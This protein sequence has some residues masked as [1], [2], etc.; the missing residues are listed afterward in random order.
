MDRRRVNLAAAA[1]WFLAAILNYTPTFAADNTEGAGSNGAVNAATVALLVPENFNLP[2]LHKIRL[3]QIIS[4][5]LFVNGCTKFL[6]R[7]F[8]Q[9]RFSADLSPKSRIVTHAA[10]ADRSS[11]QYGFLDSRNL[12]YITEKSDVWFVAHKLFGRR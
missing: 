8:L 1:P 3:Q 7:E 2:L 5:T 4:K 12:E 9:R 6:H 10:I 11:G